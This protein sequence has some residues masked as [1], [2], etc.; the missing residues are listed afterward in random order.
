MDPSLDPYAGI[1]RIRFIGIHRGIA[2][3]YKVISAGSTGTPSSSNGQA[4]AGSV[5]AYDVWCV[6]ASAAHA[7]VQR[8]ASSPIC[9]KAVSRRV[10]SRKVVIN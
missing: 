6:K 1:S 2:K 3:R 9:Q 8:P 10:A 7:R 4:I 5:W